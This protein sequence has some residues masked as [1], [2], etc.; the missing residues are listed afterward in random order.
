MSEM[1]TTIYD[2]RQKESIDWKGLQQGDVIYIYLD[3]NMSV[4]DVPFWL[5]LNIC[6]KILHDKYFKVYYGMAVVEEVVS[7]GAKNTND[8]VVK[9]MPE[10]E[11][12]GYKLYK[13]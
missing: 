7:H 3:F 4:K 8:D 5:Q 10:L 9:L 13:Y 11:E 2:Y 6:F 1:I 12:N